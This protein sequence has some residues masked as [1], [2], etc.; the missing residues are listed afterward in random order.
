MTDPL[1]PSGAPLPSPIALR[2][3]D[4]AAIAAVY[5]D[6]A[7]GLLRT[8]TAMLGER[9][10]A[11]D[12]VHD[13][14]VGLPEAMGRYQERGQFGGWLHRI[15][16]RMAISKLRRR[17]RRG[18]VAIEAADGIGSRAT[19]D[20][21]ATSITVTAALAALP[22]SLRTVVVLREYE[23]WPHREIAAHLG[24]SEGAVMTRHCRALQK[25]RNALKEDR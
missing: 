9:S 12:V 3:G 1:R 13:L 22:E 10:E 8:L 19:G 2:Q 25:L 16:V 18:E 4:P 5:R 15:A 11:E 7:P 6:H 23:G 14:F 24:I 17:G 20:S 21:V